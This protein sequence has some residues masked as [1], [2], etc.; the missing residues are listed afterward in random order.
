MAMDGWNSQTREACKKGNYQSWV[1]MG[2]GLADGNSDIWGETI[3]FGLSCIYTENYWVNAGN[4][5]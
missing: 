4:F 2:P 3:V 5:L 1:A